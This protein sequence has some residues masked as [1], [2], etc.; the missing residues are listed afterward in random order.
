MTLCIPSFKKKFLFCFASHKKYP[1]YSSEL[2]YKL[3]HEKY[4]K[5]TWNNSNQKK[6]TIELLVNQKCK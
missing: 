4:I 5:I 6:L 3:L 1:Y 2:F